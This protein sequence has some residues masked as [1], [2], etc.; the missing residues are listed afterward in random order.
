MSLIEFL[1]VI[2][3]LR[4]IVSLGIGL[5]VTWAI[6]AIGSAFIED[7]LFGEKPDVFIIVMAVLVWLTVSYG[8]I[9]WVM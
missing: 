9:A 1:R 8:V 3:V 5:V 6:F 2:E 7:V 4:V